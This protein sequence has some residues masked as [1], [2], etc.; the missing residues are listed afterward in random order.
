[1]KIAIA[2]NVCSGKTTLVNQLISYYPHYIKKSFADKIKE[3]AKELFNMKQK[4]RK[5]LQ[6]IGTNLKLI[7]E[8][9][10][11]NYALNSSYNYIIIDDLRFENEAKKLKENGWIIIKLNIS[12]ELQVERIK[13]TYPNTWLHHIGYLNHE[14]EQEF[15]NLDKYTDLKIEVDDCKNIFEKVKEY[16]YLLYIEKN[17]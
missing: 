5:L 14:S 10:W 3:I 1:M 9:V 17:I 2:G 12:K 16:I 11:I 7:D 8:E 13:K 15:D 4:D 6:Q